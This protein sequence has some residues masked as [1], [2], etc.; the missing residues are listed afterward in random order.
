MATFFGTC[1]VD[2]A[3][4]SRKHEVLHPRQIAMFLCT[5]YTDASIATI[6]SHFNRDHPAVSNSVKAVERRMLERAKLR[7]QVEE[8]IGRLDALVEEAR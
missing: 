5:R 6:A 3:S 1:P 2:L 7:Y 4:R 8:L